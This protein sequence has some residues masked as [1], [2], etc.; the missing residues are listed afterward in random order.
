MS[1]PSLQP[2]DLRT[3]CA[4]RDYCLMVDESLSMNT[5]DCPGATSRWKYV[6]EVVGLI[7][8]KCNEYDPDTGFDLIFFGENPRLYEDISPAQL[9]ETFP[10]KPSAFST[11]LG[12]AL[13][14]VFKRYFAGPKTRPITYVIMTDGEA[15]DPRIVETALRNA[16]KAS[17]SGEDLAVAFWQIGYDSGAAKFLKQLDDELGEI[18]IVDTQ[19]METVVEHLGNLELLLA[20]AIID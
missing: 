14:V 7:A 2:D 1:L 20:A 8:T 4:S 17:G 12:A 5:P 18:D 13:D 16:A 3:L 19:D 10:E 15:S 11:Q 6:K 9:S